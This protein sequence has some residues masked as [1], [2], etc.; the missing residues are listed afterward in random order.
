MVVHGCG[1]VG[2]SAVMIAATAGAR[3]IAV[4]VSPAALDSARSFG[5]E[6]TLP[7]GDEVVAAVHHH[8]GGGAHLSIDAVG[9]AATCAASI[10]G[11]RRR[12][13]H[14]QIGLLPSALGWPVV[15]MHLVIAYE[16]EVLGSH[17]MS[18]RGYPE[19]LGLVTSGRL[20]PGAL[21]TQRIGLAEVPDALVAMGSP[22]ATPGITVAL[23][24]L[25]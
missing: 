12:G 1:G 20:D 13:R 18:P 4:D 25:G 3:V 5:A 9:S 8:T 14:V 17:G 2:L 16:L 10:A 6:V 15:P 23:A 24:S 11:L 22:A 21:V 7:S 19:L